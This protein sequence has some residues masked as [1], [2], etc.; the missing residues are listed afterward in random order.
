MKLLSDKD[1]IVPGVLLD[2]GPLDGVPACTWQVVKKGTSR[3]GNVWMIQPLG[4]P[5][6]APVSICFD[7]VRLDNKWNWNIR[8]PQ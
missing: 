3:F 7:G 6:H 5:E 8:F 1:E 4:N 2:M